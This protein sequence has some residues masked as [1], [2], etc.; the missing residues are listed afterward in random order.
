MRKASNMHAASSR[1]T[2]TN[3]LP[4]HNR[5][6]KKTGIVGFCTALTLT[7]V[8]SAANAAEQT[9][10][11]VHGSFV[12]AWYWKPVEEQLGG[13]GFN[14]R[15]VDLTGSSSNPVS[16]PASTTLD[17]HILDI[18][19]AIEA[20][21]GPVVLVGHS[22]GGRPLTGAWDRARERV[23]AVIFLEAVAPYGDGPFAIPEETKQRFR[24]AEVNPDALEDGF[25]S[26][27]EYLAN[28][29]PDLEL[30]PQSLSALHEGL[31]LVRG[32]LPDTPGAY[33]VGSKSNSRIFRQHAKKVADERGWTIWEIETGHDMVYDNS[34]VVARLIAK[35]AQELPRTVSGSL[36]R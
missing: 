8:F 32:P 10:L 3:R 25:L 29:Y 35:L 28:R 30:R 5:I 26:P 36:G 16:D 33:V 31:Q 6:A 15:S 13:L 4:L 12:G 9:I 11:L 21:T 27:P 2:A 1:S 22:Y 24:L 17:D 19:T 34:D 20:T 14:A 23:S 18:V 7:A